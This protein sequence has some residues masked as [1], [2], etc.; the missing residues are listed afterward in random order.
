MS[1]LNNSDIARVNK[2][3]ALY[4]NWIWCHHLTSSDYPDGRYYRLPL[5]PEQVSDSINSKFVSTEI[6][7]RSAP[8][9]SW[10][11]AGPR[12]VR[13]TLKVHRDLDYNSLGEKVGDITEFMNEYQAATLPNY[14][15]PMQVVPPKVTVKIGNGI[16]V[17]GIPNIDCT[18]LLPLDE[19]GEYMV[20]QF[21]F[22]ITE[23]EPTDAVEVASSLHNV[24]G[25][26]R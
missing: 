7:A 14:S 23:L 22:E 15:T 12:V 18:K 2:E 19:K 1:N 9:Q 4:D 21:N 10:V 8:L 5:Y 13:F 25:M 16:R 3:Y 26:T 17:T 24:R 11:G 6:L 20:A